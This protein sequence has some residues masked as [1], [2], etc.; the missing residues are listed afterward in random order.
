MK[1]KVRIEVLYGLFLN[2]KYER[3]VLLD[4]LHVYPI[5]LLVCKLHASVIDNYFHGFMLFKIKIL[6]TLRFTLTANLA[7]TLRLL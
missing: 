1:K 2:F 6:G 4:D 5:G 3:R 7:Q